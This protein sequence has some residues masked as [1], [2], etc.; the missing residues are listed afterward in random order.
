MNLF[1]LDESNDL[2]SQYHVDKHVIKM[3]VEI[4]QMLCTAHHVLNPSSNIPYRLSHKN[5]PMSIW[6]RS[7]KE[8]YM[9]ALDLG[10][11]LCEELE[12]RKGTKVQKVLDTLEWCKNNIHNIKFDSEGLTTPPSCM[13][14]NTKIFLSPRCL[15]E[16]I[17]NY[18][19]YYK[20]DK[21]HLHKWSDRDIPWWL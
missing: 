10:F 18:R 9:F 5:H 8:N 13:P 12:Y 20:K 15:K 7:S 14:D 16:V 11:R 6:V 17:K 2:S 21:K 3:R 19:N 1:F 4:A